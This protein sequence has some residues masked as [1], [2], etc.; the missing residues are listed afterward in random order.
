VQ[1]ELDVQLT[2]RAVQEME[3]GPVVTYPILLA[4]ESTITVKLESS[5][6]LAAAPTAGAEGEAYAVVIK[7]T[8]AS[9]GK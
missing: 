8:R 6:V 1:L 4:A 7:V 9:A 2:G 5:V 3:S